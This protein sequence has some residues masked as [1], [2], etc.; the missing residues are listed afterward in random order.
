MT[1]DC[2]AVRVKNV[3][4][5]YRLWATSH[6]RLILPLKNLIFSFIPTKF[7]KNASLPEKTY[8]EFYA[9]NDISFDIL[10]G[11]SWGVIGVNGSGK[12]TLLKIIAGN[13][14]P[15]SGYVEVDGK[16]VILDYGNGFNGDFTGK[17]NIYIKAA[18]LGLTRKQIHE[19]YESIVAF[20]ELG[21]FIHQPVKT[22]SSGMSARLGFA[23]IAHVDA[24]IIITDEALAVGDV[25]FVQK[26]MRFIQNFLKKGTFFL[27]SH[28]TNDIV[29]LCQKA[30]WLEK[31]TI[32][33][34]GP[35]T[36][37]AK[38]YLHHNNSDE[39]NEHE[40]DNDEQEPL[41]PEEELSQSMFVLGH[42]VSSKLEQPSI[43]KDSRINY[44][45]ADSPTNKMY[46]PTFNVNI[47]NS[48]KVKITSV[49][50][51]DEEGIFISQIIGGELITLCIESTAIDE[52]SF[53]IIGFHVL[54]RLGQIL[55]A[56][57]TYL[58]SH[59]EPYLFKA[60]VGYATKFCFQMPL[61]PR[62]V[63]V[64]RAM[65]G[66]LSKDKTIET[67]YIDHNAFAFHSVTFGE[68]HGLIG[69]PLQSIKLTC[70][71]ITIN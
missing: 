38:A 43:F 69:V 20:A 56:D 18:L 13:L 52:L 58:S 68:R 34:I 30:I 70:Q 24:D 9:L 36:K 66:V 28:S 35:A 60:N 10:K 33:A 3:S 31:G 46:M 2:Y 40:L 8:R 41:T 53:P 21:N 42:P 55:F 12:S 29:S 62:G 32:K 71:S 39:L 25:F 19:R 11:E 44:F 26:C 51:H 47:S 64:I 48:N 65:I 17:E 49:T 4:K 22:Y 54:D 67:L 5:I 15:S 61:L 45:E 50:L 57:T 6:D 16:V 63:Y 1:T 14:R 27:V 59:K 23:I 7:H 37:I